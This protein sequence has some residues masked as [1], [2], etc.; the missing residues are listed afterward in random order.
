MIGFMAELKYPIQKR[1]STTR[2]GVFTRHV[3]HTVIVTYPMK[4]G[5]Q[6]AMKAPM[7]MPRV[8]AALCSL[9]ILL[10]LLLVGVDCPD[11]GSS[12]A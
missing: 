1:M 12:A 9:F 2:G 7:M 6:Q 5:N 10:I 4:K 8:L 11:S 3:S